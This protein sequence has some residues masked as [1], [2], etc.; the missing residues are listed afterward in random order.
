MKTGTCV[1]IGLMFVLFHFAIAQDQPPT[2]TGTAT[3]T[4][5]PVEQPETPAA[6]GEKPW[7]ITLTADFLTQYFY[8]GYAV[9]TKGWIVQPAIDFSYTV[10]DQSSLSLTPHVGG[11]FNV[12]EEKG[13]SDP[14]HLA[15]ADLFTGVA[16]GY[17]NFELHADYNFQGYPSGFGIAQGSGE[18]QEAEFTLSYDDSSHWPK[19][20]P[21]AA[22]Y[23]HVGYYHE[24]QDRND[25]DCNA[26]LELGVEPT[27]QDFKL[28][29][30]A[31][32]VSFPVIV[33]LSTDSYY[34]DATGGNETLGYWLAG[35]KAAIA[36]DERWSIVGEVDYLRLEATSVI[37]ANGGDGDEVIGRIGI[38]CSL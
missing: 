31:V 5:Q 10:Y 21:L 28:A 14:Q 34:R 11:W 6:E 3:N 16:V 22:I 8:R 4:Q 24:I 20:S 9:V 23:P 19:D 37:D 25:H 35:F 30:R 13:P 36:L 29:D 7:A 27:L 33:G 26:Y 38:N 17:G 15:E 18:V 2:N 1:C 32:T 12:T